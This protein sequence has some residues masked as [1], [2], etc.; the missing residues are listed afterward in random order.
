VPLLIGVSRKKMI[1]TL[2]D[3]APVGERLGGSIA[4]ALHGIAQGV[5]IVRLHDVA[6]TVQAVRL[7][8]AVG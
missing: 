4:L 1:G 2:S 5:Q 6:A 3:N 7:W 8:Q